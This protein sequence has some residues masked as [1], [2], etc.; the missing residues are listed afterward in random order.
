MGRYRHR[1]PY[2]KRPVLERF[3]EKVRKTRGCWYWKASTAGRGYGVFYYEGRQQYSHRVSYQL[4][5]GPIPDGVDI[6]HH[7]DNPACVKP[8]HLFEG[9]DIEN[10][11]D[12]IV[13][14]R[15]RFNFRVNPP[16]GNKSAAGKPAWNRILNE[17]TALAIRQSGGTQAEIAAKYGVS[18][19]HVSNIRRG[20]SWV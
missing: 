17:K 3:F 7:C 8:S 4:F 5:V 10:V 6:L 18:R 16:F 12:M 9:T 13:K 2:R 11:R 14:G 15:D 19:S 20:H 1:G